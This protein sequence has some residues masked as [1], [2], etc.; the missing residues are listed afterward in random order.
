MA[1]TVNSLNYANTFLH[2]MNSTNDLVVENNVLGK[3][4]Y[5]KD[6]GTLY[7]DETTT[8]LE[9]LGDAKFQK[10]LIVTGTGSSATIDNNLTIKYGTTYLKRDDAG[11]ANIALVA[12]GQANVDGILFANG[13]VT[14]L[15]TT[16]NA[17]V[18]GNTTI[19]Y[20][21]TTNKL[22]SNVSVLTNY[23]TANTY[24]WTDNLQAN[25]RVV[26]DIAQANTLVITEDVQANTTV[27]T[28]GL[29]VTTTTYTKDLQANNSTNTEI[30][31]ANVAYANYLTSNSQ[32]TA[33][34]ANVTNDLYG[35]RVTANTLL[36]NTQLTVSGA[37]VLAGETIY[38]S[39]NFTINAASPTGLTSQF[40][41]NR[42][43]S[44]SNASLRFN[45]DGADSYWDLGRTGTFYRIITDEHKNDTITSTS[46]TA[47]ATA[48]S[49]N[50]VNSIGTTTGRYANSAFS[51]ANSAYYTA[52]SAQIYA[53]GAFAQANAGFTFANGAFVQ[54]NAA[55]SRANTAAN[56][57]VG[58][59]GS[60]AHSSGVISFSGNNGMTVV[61]TSANNLAIGT[62]QD[63]RTTASPTF[64]SLTLTAPLGTAQGGTGATTTAQ[65]LTNL[66]PSGTTA[67]YVLT[68]G[69]AGNFYWAAASGGGGGA[70]PGTSINSTRLSFTA[71]GAAGY[72]GNSYSGFAATSATQ[73]RAY[74]NG[75]RQFE[76]EYNLTLGSANT[77]AFTTTPTS[78][79]KVLI[80]VDGYYVNPLYAN[81]TAFTVN[82]DISSS[83]NT[84]QLAIDGLTSKLVTYYAN[85]AATPTFTTVAKGI[86]VAAGTS[87]T[88]FATTAYVQG[89]ANNSGTLTT[90]ITGN[91]GTVTN[92]V[93]TTGDQTIGGTKTFSTKI[94][95]SISGNCDG[96]A[97]N[98]TAYTINQSVGTG[99][100][101]TFANVSVNGAIT[102]T[103]D[104]TAFY[105]ASDRSL[106][107]NVITLTGALDSLDS[108]NAYRFNYISRP[109]E[110]MV[111]VMAQEI[112][113]VYPELVYKLDP[114][115]ENSKLAV[116]YELLT[117]VL[118]QSI[119][120]LKAEV[121]ALKGQI[122]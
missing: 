53:N 54:A 119:K 2:W 106:K 107:E 70:T 50:A 17:I 40:I 74:I 58:T 112:Q 62:P 18:G 1:N 72:S 108:L 78:G 48:N 77:V 3:G 57:F 81:N 60:V 15:L 84:I 80:E 117:A 5:H 115:D 37:F 91:A 83:A 67:G 122:K 99:N 9:T 90:S 104:I 36:V 116:R 52:N 41:V 46:T 8:S 27:N 92:G 63:L 55:F 79:D 102:A 82:S 114:T 66:L 89:L 109:N 59:T 76:S 101:P 121:D 44:G 118:L 94:S 33:Y 25:T 45:E 12:H 96:T 29:S 28:T 10:E 6:G 35:E 100:S 13:P 93:Y 22:Q 39:N 113:Q 11:V 64:A 87:N 31:T 51:Y 34:N 38:D 47:W 105:D 120:E 110:P 86:T 24:A 97:N 26:T 42:G 68:T 69:G 23:F 98:I 75:V 19:R 20:N 73:V 71:N 32:V 30:S 88:A 7:L 103:G 111:G 49:V 61:A 16:N 56:T 65:A 95:G 43:S 4:N 85:I 14:S 21:T